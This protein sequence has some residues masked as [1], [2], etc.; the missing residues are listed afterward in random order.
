LILA[1][2]ARARLLLLLLTRLLVLTT[3]LLAAL[4]TALL[5]LARLLVLILVLLVHL[6]I[7]KGWSEATASQCHPQR[8]DN[9]QAGCRVP[10]GTEA[11][12]QEFP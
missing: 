6:H 4:L 3:L 1:R 10:F 11:M 12:C 8:S 2:L 5:L 9:A 7:S